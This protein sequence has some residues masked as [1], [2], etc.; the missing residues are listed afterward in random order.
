M[1]QYYKKR[2]LKHCYCKKSR[3]TRSAEKKLIAAIKPAQ[4]KALIPIMSRIS[5]PS[6]WNIIA[7]SQPILKMVST[8]FC[9]NLKDSPKTKP[10]ANKVTAPT[11]E[12]IASSTF[13]IRKIF[14][15]SSLITTV[16][17]NI[18]RSSFLPRKRP[19]RIASDFS[20]NG[21][22]MTAVIG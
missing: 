16:G 12:M 1:H 11:T 14:S 8:S 21:R 5:A 6:N 10:I 9:R 7:L 2:P 20:S 3:R 19:C 17:R 18:C 15:S 4:H 13:F 22:A